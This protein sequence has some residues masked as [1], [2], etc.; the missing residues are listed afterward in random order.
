MR[1]SGWTFGKGRWITVGISIVVLIVSIVCS[2]TSSLVTLIREVLSSGAMRNTT[3]ISIKSIA[4]SRC[5]QHVDCI[6][7]HSDDA[8]A[9]P[10]VVRGM[11]TLKYHMM[12]DR[13]WASP[14]P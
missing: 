9:N 4:G 6:V 11:E 10:D 14:F 8:L 3:Q 12:E 5:G 1:M 13:M 2:S 7:G